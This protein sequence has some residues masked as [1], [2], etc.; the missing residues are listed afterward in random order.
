MRLNLLNGEN[1]G[2]VCNMQGNYSGELFCPINSEE[3]TP[4]QITPTVIIYKIY[5]T[6]M[7]ESHVN[8]NS[9]STL[10]DKLKR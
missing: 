8:I 10:Q 9:H 6:K 2:S 1:K 5:I 3:L 4:T 7:S